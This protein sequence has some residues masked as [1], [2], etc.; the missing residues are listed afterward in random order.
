MASI[1]LSYAHD[2]RRRAEKVARAL[3]N[4][5]H[6]VW[7]DQQIHAGSRFSKD[8]D[9]ALRRADLVV[10][11]WSKRSIESSWVHDEAAYGRDKSRLVPVLVENVE[12]PLG[13]RQYQ[14]IRIG[15]SNADSVVQAV[16]SILGAV[17]DNEVPAAKRTA[18]GSSVKKAILAIGVLLAA[19]AGWW[20]YQR[21]TASARSSLVLVAAQGTNAPTVSVI[22]EK[23]AGDLRRFNEG[24]ISALEIEP[25]GSRSF[26]PYI[27]E[28]RFS[29]SEQQVIVGVALS[30]G[31][32]D[33]LWSTTLEGE[34]SRQSDLVREAAARLGSALACDLDEP[35]RRAKLRDEVRALYLEGCARMADASSERD[36]KAILALRQ[37]TEKV[38][39]FAAGWA[40]LALAEFKALPAAPSREKSNLAWTVGRHTEMAKRLDPSLPEIFYIRAFNGPDYPGFMAKALETV[41]QGLRISPDS[42]LLVGARAEILANL[43]M[44][45]EALENSR[46]AIELSPLSPS[47]LQNYV[48]MLAYDGRL[49]AARKQLEDAQQNW[50]RSEAVIELKYLFDLRYGD[51]ADALRMIR[52]GLVPAGSDEGQPLYLQARLNPTSSNID[53][54]LNH[55][56]T[57]YEKDPDWSFP[58]LQALGTFDKVDEAYRVLGSAGGVDPFTRDGEGL[59]RPYMRSIRADPRFMGVAQRTGM[60]AFWRKGGVWPDFCRDPQIEYNCEKEAAKYPDEPA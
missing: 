9:A 8:I 50:P 20:A 38:P 25:N 40:Q 36:D 34:A 37:V 28:V 5:G 49:D 58:Y 54:V 1:F 48:L 51:P 57:I 35:V 29:E 15:R 23:M 4:A 6:T 3:G 27:A 13:F 43:G 53:A 41:E 52:D 31:D 11:L 59:F 47:Y 21:L 12:P 22:I 44:I 16:A 39:N 10:V 7:W 32:G 46:R 56:R 19:F 14:S 24:P 45:G 33:R 26:A 42:A 60:L 18:R 30:S 55:Y 17:R 2:D